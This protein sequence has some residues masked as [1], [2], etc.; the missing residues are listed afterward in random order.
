M[1]ISGDLRMKLETIP[2]G[3]IRMSD[4]N[5]RANEPFGDE[6]DDEFVKNIEALGILEPI[7]VRPVG[8]HFVVDVGRRRFLSAQKLGYKELDCIVRES[9][10]LDAMDASIS[11]NVFRKNVDPV[12][13]GMWIKLRLDKGDISLSQYARRI[14]KAKS[15]LSEWMRM[16]DLTIEMQ[17]QVR[18]QAVP[19]RYALK[20]AR[21]NLSKPEEK[22]LAAE[23]AKGGFNA[24]KEK[25]DGIA[26]TREKRGAPKGL[27]IVRI[28][29]GQESE[30][31]TKL[32]QLAAK[33]GVDLSNYCS[34]ILKE[35]AKRAKV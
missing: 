2:I 35:H 29:F 4:Q 6:Q 34:K 7:I 14:G 11:E 20:V 15:T 17:E 28:S 21:L 22:A 27:K 31:Y 32:Q 24:F 30:E 23:A 9:T 1:V 12:T 3:S 19:F 10:E 25:V 18:S 26:A 33:K 5:I 8:D 16:T 13:L